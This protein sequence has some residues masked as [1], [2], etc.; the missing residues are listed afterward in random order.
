MQFKVPNAKVYSRAARTTTSLTVSKQ[1]KSGLKKLA[2]AP[3]ENANEVSERLDIPNGKW[4]QQ[5]ATRDGSKK[6]GYQGGTIA[7]A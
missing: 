6:A 4:A 2:T 5:I 7:Y 3:R 1:G